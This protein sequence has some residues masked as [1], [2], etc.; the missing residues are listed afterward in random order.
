M[1]MLKK[2]FREIDEAEEKAYDLIEMYN[3]EC[4]HTAEKCAISR[5]LIVMTAQIFRLLSCA[6]VIELL[7]GGILGLLLSRLISSLF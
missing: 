6:L 1:G 5:Y 4:G 7:A 3:K 2:L